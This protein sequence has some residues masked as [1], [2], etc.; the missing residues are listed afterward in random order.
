MVVRSSFGQRINFPS[1]F[2]RRT[3]RITNQRWLIYS[4]D[5][6]VVPREV[7][8]FMRLIHAKS[9]LNESQSPHRSVLERQSSNSFTLIEAIMIEEAVFGCGNFRCRF[10]YLPITSSHSGLCMTG[11]GKKKY[12]L[13]VSK[14]R[15]YPICFRWPLASG[16]VA[17]GPTRTGEVALFRERSIFARAAR[18]GKYT[19]TKIVPPQS[20][21]ISMSLLGTRCFCTSTVNLLRQPSP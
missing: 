20:D 13:G 10:V 17:I 15:R 6:R 1:R 8:I 12:R 18:I 7:V 9:S 4:I 16:C 11:I 21:R 19:G 5:D 14:R 2:E 3:E